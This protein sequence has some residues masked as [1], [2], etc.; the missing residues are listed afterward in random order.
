[1]SSSPRAEAAPDPSWVSRVRDEIDRAVKRSI[2]G[3]EY[4]AAEPAEVG[5]TP[6]DVI[7]SRGTLSLYHYR[8]MADEIY[9]IPLLLVMATTNKAYIFDLAP[10]QSLVEFLLKAG[11]DVY[12]MDWNPPRPDEAGLRFEDYTQRFIPECVRRVQ[13]DSGVQ[14][15]NMIG[16]CM[17][18]V[19]ATMY[20][21][22]HADGPVKN[23]VCFT[24]PIDFSKMTEFQ[25]WSNRRHFKVD[26]MADAFGIVPAPIITSGFDALRPTGRLTGNIRLWDNLWNDAYVKQYRMMDRWGAETLPLAGAYFKQT[27]KTLMWDN[28]LFNGTLKIGGKTVDLGNIKLPLLSIV[29]E[30]DHIVPYDAAHPLMEKV[31]S[32]DKEEVILKGGHVS[33]VAGPNAVKRMWPKLDQW[34]GGRS[35]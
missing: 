17:G 21:A 15:V 23:L 8:P 25:A 30:H 14:D 32:T 13:E 1:M 3:V 20:A 29:A 16:Y 35:I 34:L 31:G 10:G 22:T 9:R 5:P 18:G 4:L 2:K 19:L 24:T 6:K 7:Y 11:Y 28:A 33:L 26:K 12:V 27:I